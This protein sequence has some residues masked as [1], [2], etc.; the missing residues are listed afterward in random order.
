MSVDYKDENEI[1]DDLWRHGLSFL[2]ISYVLTVMRRPFSRNA[3]AGK[4]HRLGLTRSNTG[5]K[6]ITELK[7]YLLSI[8]D[9]N[10]QDT[11]LWDQVTSLLV[12]AIFYESSRKAALC[13]REI[14][15][16]LN[17]KGI[18]TLPT[19]QAVKERSIQRRVTRAK[20]KAE[21]IKLPV[22][23][24]APVVETPQEDFKAKVL[25]SADAAPIKPVDFEAPTEKVA[26][27]FA[28][29]KKTRVT[30]NNKGRINGMRPFKFRANT[31]KTV[32]ELVEEEKVVKSENT[33]VSEEALTALRNREVSRQPSAPLELKVIDEAEGGENIT[34]VEL[35][36]NSCRWP[37]GTNPG[38]QM[39]FC[40]K[41]KEI[42][43][44]FSFC[45]GH[46]V[47]AVTKSS[48]TSNEDYTARIKKRLATTASKKREKEIETNEKFFETGDF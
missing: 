42:G 43:A 17:T 16:L 2:A 45:S 18:T 32:D 34:L 33:H 47:E 29:T 4:C 6:P 37:V 9:K 31:S 26:T 35:R 38:G 8:V 25:E 14:E 44:A 3:V 7:A 10:R 20:K 46:M 15:E 28:I 39:L 27:D 36:H 5:K 24:A 30:I 21:A 19:I 48:V 23:E 12:R 22:A 11:E 40:G 41:A 13:M 1:I